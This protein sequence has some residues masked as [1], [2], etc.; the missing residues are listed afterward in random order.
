MDGYT[1]TK[2]IREREKIS[3]KH[4]PIIAITAY[5]LKGWPFGKL[6]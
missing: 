3:S 1:A 6:A 4:T 5:A 2:T